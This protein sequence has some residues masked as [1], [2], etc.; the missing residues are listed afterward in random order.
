MSIATSLGRPFRILGRRAIKLG[1]GARSAKQWWLAAR[2]YR[3][4]VML[5]PKRTDVLSQIGNAYRENGEYKNAIKFYRRSLGVQS[6]ADTFFQLGLAYIRAGD[7]DLARAAFQAASD[8]GHPLA[9]DELEYLRT[10]DIVESGQAMWGFRSKIEARHLRTR[11]WLG[12]L[13]EIPYGKSDPEIGRLGFKIAQSGNTTIKIRGE[14]HAAAFGI[15]TVRG[16]VTATEEVD[17][18]MLYVG[19]ERIGLASPK[20]FDPHLKGARY[21]YNI[22]FDASRLP[23]G[24]KSF[25]LKAYAGEQMLYETSFSLYVLPYEENSD[26]LVSDS[27]ITPVAGDATDLVKEVAERPAKMRS[28]RRGIDRAKV[29]TIYVQRLDQLGDLSAS[30]DALRDLRTTFSSA[31]IV[32]SASRSVI[33]FV[34]SFDVVDEYVSIDLKYNFRTEKRFINI[35][36]VNTAFR[37]LARY[38][39]DLGIDLCPGAETRPILRLSN[40][41]YL[42]GFD[43]H[44][45]DFLDFG[46]DVVSR[47]KINSKANVSH[48][49]TVRTLVKAIQAL[50]EEVEAPERRLRPC[51]DGVVIHTG[52]RHRLNKWSLL[53]YVSLAARLKSVYNL[54]VTLFVDESDED[55]EVLRQLPDGVSVSPKVSM[56][57]FVEIV[58][59]AALFV[60]NDSGPKHMAAA[61]GVPCV[62]VHVNRLNWGEWG[63]H[64]EGIIVTKPVPCAGCG[65]NVFEACGL[66]VVC[67]NSISVDEVFDACTRTLGSALL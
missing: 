63:Q 40:A 35:D 20:K 55:N 25:S 54:H 58:A 50:C 26:L 32:F 15:A 51:G 5:A 27:Y 34:R 3:A 65:L 1:N 45:F 43:P 30:L 17:A 19:E 41:K 31:K 42:I 39:F 4:G 29:K 67:L 48:H 52:A 12:S 7:D 21:A 10:K 8:G 18:V 66:D 38:D 61:L 53:K 24:L 2:L 44:R 47:D 59:G 23:V 46:I 37:Q 49:S 9:F 62:S 11:A 6:S 22:W 13:G 16:H 60:G 64:G 36:E 33:D 56:Q 28:A 57:R 14:Q